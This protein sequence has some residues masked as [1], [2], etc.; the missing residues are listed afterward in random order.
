ML[1]NTRQTNE[2]ADKQADY[3]A[4]YRAAIRLLSRREYAANELNDKLRQ[5]GHNSKLINRLLIDLQAKGYQSEARYCEMFVR[6]RFHQHYGPI[7]IGY[8]LKQK[9]ISSTLIADELSKYENEWSQIIAELLARKRQSSHP[10]AD[11]KLIKF[12]LGKGFDYSLIKQ[13][14]NR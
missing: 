7:K 1:N 11:D 12:L 8:E 3:Q 4:A 2:Q 10:P 6:T 5:Q 9:G 13:V 14:F